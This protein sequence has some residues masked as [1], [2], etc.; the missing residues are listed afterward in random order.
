MCDLPG[1]SLCWLPSCQA[2]K[3]ENIPQLGSGELRLSSTVLKR[4][5][6]SHSEETWHWWTQAE[7]HVT[8][9]KNLLPKLKKLIIRN[10][11]LGSENET[12]QNKKVNWSSTSRVVWK[13]GRLHTDTLTF[14]FPGGKLRLRG[15]PSVWF[16][17]GLELTPRSVYLL[18]R[19]QS[20]QAMP[21][22][23]LHKS[24]RVIQARRRP[25]V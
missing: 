4:N 18:P 16:L 9:K 8:Q 17:A 13:S 22:P 15:D 14:I 10:P 23:G 3:N 11:L 20:L 24:P 12:K 5:Q 25:V 2:N 7:P 21:C 1:L 6:A 19:T